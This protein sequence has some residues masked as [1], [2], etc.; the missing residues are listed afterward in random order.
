MSVNVE[1]NNGKF[2]KSKISLKRG[3]HIRFKSSDGNTYTV[4]CG[5][6]D[7]EISDDFPFTIPGDNKI[8]K[9]KIS[10]KAKKDKNFAC[11]ITDES[12]TE[13]VMMSASSPTMI[14]EV[15]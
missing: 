5:N 12:K 14:I 6:D 8:H 11:T 3:Q 2:N 15:E 9:L 1:L 10:D 13:K 4:D 7:P